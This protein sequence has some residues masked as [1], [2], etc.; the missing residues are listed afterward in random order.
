MKKKSLRDQ[1]SSA[2]NKT[3]T[4]YIITN[5]LTTDIRDNTFPSSSSNEELADIFANFFVENVNKIR[6][7]FKHNENYNIPTRNCNM[8]SYFQTITE[9]ELFNTIKTMNITTSS[10]DPCNTKFILNFSEILVTVWTKVINKSIVE[11][12]VLK[13]WKEATILPIQKNH[14]LGMDLTNYPPISNLAFFSKCIEKVIL[15]ELWNHFKINKLILNYQSA[16]RANHLTETAIL[17]LCDNILQNMENNINTTMVALD[18]SAAFDT[19]NH[20]ILL[21]VLNKYYGIQGVALQ[22]IKSYLANRQ[23]QIQI[24]D[25]FLEVKTIDLSVPQGSILGP[26]RF[27]C[28]ARTLQESSQATTVYL[29]MLMTTPSLNHSHL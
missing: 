16:H 7:E 3:K 21:E 24:E 6:S 19:V 22:W 18:L 14:K 25:K 12:T 28:Y 29:D 15:K 13:Y 4:L 10:N 23:F 2:K 1:F 11:G 8:L 26:I 5:T 9:E 20:K 17:N 27:T